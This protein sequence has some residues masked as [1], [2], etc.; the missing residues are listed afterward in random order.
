[1]N[2]NPLP[3]GAA[4]LAAIARQEQ[5]LEVVDREDAMRRFLAAVE[6]RPLPAETVGLLA[7]LGRPLAADILAP[8]DAPPFDRSGVDGFAL[9]AAD[10]IGA[11]EATPVRLRLNGEVLTCGRAPETEVRA[12]TATVIATGAPI[13]RGADAV[14]LVEQTDIAETPVGPE[15]ILVRP[16]APGQFIGSA[17]S[18]IARG[19]L[20]LRA[21]TVLGARE[22]AQLAAVG[23]AEVAVVRRPVV[24]VLSTGDELVAPGQPLGPA[25]VYDANGA[26]I[27]ATVIENGGTAR[28]FGILPDDAGRLTDAIERALAEADLVVLSGGTSKGAG[29]L[30]SRVIARLGEPGILV[31]GVA[32]KPGKPLCLAKVRGKPLVVLPG[33]PTSAMF[34]FASFVVP[35]IRMLAGLPPEP[36]AEVVADLPAR[37]VSERGRAEFVMV[38]LVERTDG[39]LAA[40]PTAKGS[41]AVTAFTQ[42]DGFFEVPALTEGVE[43][44]SAVRVRLFGRSVAP[45]D[46]V[47][48]GSHCLGLDVIASALGRR[49]LKVRVLALGSAAGLS[50]A[51]RGECDI[52]PVHL[53]D[54]RTGTYNAPFL[55]QG[56]SLV[57]GWRRMQGV[58]F[59]PG[60]PRFEGR[61]AA[62]A[63]RAVL[64]DPETVMVNRNVGSGTRALVESLVGPARPTGWWNQPKSH[65][66]VA[67]AVSR[68]S[69]DW[70]V[71]IRTVA[72]LYGLGFLP[73]AEEHYDLIVVD[74]RRNRPAVRSFL[75]ALQQADVAERLAALGL[76]KETASA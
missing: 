42:A 70:G 6:P 11:S 57:P 28:P 17:G 52:A 4:R 23:I 47:I 40:V 66:A 34:T 59:R 33:F 3:P 26:V 12:G 31:H 72:D 2:A 21:G 75:E 60:D 49:G 46:L 63:V 69:A 14:V 62:D 9:R 19:E 64:A 16:A 30:S 74:A 51:R 41:G 44:G 73:L 50:A 43:A 25:A 54:P 1:M 15:V 7:A 22:V 20:M 71:S 18:D 67:A 61:S 55:T 8:V 53:F 36:E 5:F 65:N 39:G 76:V 27:A 24:A 10:T 45:P 13:P 35:V 68:G 32:L 58:V 37:V 48:A 56:L 29:D 38:S